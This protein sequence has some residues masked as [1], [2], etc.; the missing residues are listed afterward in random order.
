MVEPMRALDRKLWRDLWHIRGPVLAIA[1]VVGC[2]IAT[3]VMSLGTVNSL[4]EIRAAYYERNRFADVFAHAKRA[5]QRLARKIA[6]IPGVKRVETRIVEDVTVDVAGQDEPAVGRLV[7]IPSRGRPLLNDLTLRRGRLPAP[8]HAGEVVLSEA[9]AEAHGLIPGDTVSALM[10]GRKRVLHVV[11]VALSPEFVYA[12]GPGVLVPDNRRFGVLWMSWDALAAA[13]DLEGAFNDVTLALSRGAPVAAVTD[14]LDALLEP[15]GGIGAYGRDDQ[16][17]NAYLVGEMD[18]LEALTG[19]A[20]P[21]FLAVAVFLLNVVMSRLIQSDRAEIGLLKAFGYANRAVGWH[22]LQFVLVI[23]VLGLALGFAGGAWLGQ[24]L[25]RLYAEFFR[26]PI[27]QYYLYPAVFASAGL[28]TLALAVAGTIGAVRRAVALPPAVAMI[29]APP[30]SYRKGTAERLLLGRNAA[31]ATRMMVRNIV[32]W[33][34]RAAM[35]TLGVS[36]AVT[37]LV[38]SLFF[39]DAF[40]HM[41]ETYFHHANR[42]DAAVTFNQPRGQR[43]LADVRHLQGVRAAEGY[44]AVPVRLRF[45]HLEQRTAIDGIAENSDLRRILDTHLRPVPVPGE[46][47][48]LSTHLAETLG[49]GRGDRVTVEALE[50]RRPVARIPV[51]AIAEEYLGAPAYMERSALN[52]F[53]GEGPVV[54]GAYLMVDGRQGPALYRRLKD[55]PAVAG[56]SV[57]AADLKTFRE[58]I[59]EHINHMNSFYVAFAALIA[60]GVVYNSARISLSERAR[61]LATLRVMGFTR[62]EVSVI[63]LGELAVLTLIALPLGCVLGYGL[64]ALMAWSF[65]TDLY[66]VPLVVEHSTFGIAVVVV[67]VASLLSGLLVRRRIDRLDLTEVLKTRE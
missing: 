36:L 17:S 24:A 14:R 33:P 10:N 48:V 30:A 56:V 43:V 50:G 62:M 32:R 49:A 20:P 26:F 40:D 58:T 23:T 65:E 27:L 51:T 39:Y 42:Y 64:A 67:S 31:Q 12:I 55:T 54:S 1:L 59:E 11:G 52:R 47:L 57:L 66:R 3:Y 25:T 34:L 18:Q 44:R 15:Y 38:A 29:P 46:G 19:I 4:A 28:F 63:L 61:D 45:G 8:G 21:I 41:I 5:P 35:T 2:G 6:R 37:I 16:L 9:F 7:S 60:I 22:Y 53:M 13:F